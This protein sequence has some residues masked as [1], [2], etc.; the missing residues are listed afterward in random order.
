MISLTHKPRRALYVAF[1]ALL[2]L[3]QITNAQT[4]S[5]LSTQGFIRKSFGSD[6]ITV[7]TSSIGFTAG[8]I[9][10]TCTDVSP[11][12]CRASAAS[13]SV[14]TDAVRVLTTGVA[15]TATT[16]FLVASGT[17]FTVYGYNDISAFRAIRVTADSTL[18]CIYYR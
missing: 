5:T 8:T 6:K 11:E 17:S 16:G 18:N 7:S 10:P 1:A 9:S 12:Y 13:C 2:C 14:E 3:V 15:P 4:Q